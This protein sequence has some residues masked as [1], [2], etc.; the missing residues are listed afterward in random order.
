MFLFCSLV[1]KKHIREYL[2]KMST[3]I[4]FTY[5]NTV[6]YNQILK[7]LLIQKIQ[8]WSFI[9]HKTFMEIHSKTVVQHS[10]KQLRLMGTYF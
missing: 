4:I 1:S 6:A 7:E 2:S 3:L 5:I 9:V 8:R 10:P